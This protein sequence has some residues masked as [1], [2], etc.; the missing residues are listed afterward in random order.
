MNVNR[1]ARECLTGVS[2]RK[3]GLT[4][5]HYLSPLSIDHGQMS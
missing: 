2:M 5:K 1:I 4:E 3:M